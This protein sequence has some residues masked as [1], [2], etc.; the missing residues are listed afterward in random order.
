MTAM[1]IAFVYRRDCFLTDVPVPEGY[2]LAR[3]G[4]RFMA[5]TVDVVIVL[6][7]SAPL[8]LQ[9]WL[10]HHGIPWGDRMQAELPEL[11]NFILPGGTAAAS[12]AHV[13]RTVCRRSERRM[14]SMLPG[15]DHADI[16][17]EYARI[18]SYLNRLSDYLFT[19]ARYC[20]RKQGLNDVL[21]KG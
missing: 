20:N 4:R 11:S 16:P 14:V 1:L 21:W 12:W 19:V 7:W 3:I 18:L 6:C 15:G 17:A 8:L 2:A 10:D 9:P 5:F 13:A